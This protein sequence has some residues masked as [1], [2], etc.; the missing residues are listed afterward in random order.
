MDG[1]VKW[2]PSCQESKPHGAASFCDDCGSKLENQLPVKNKW[3]PGCKERKSGLSKFCGD[4]GGKLEDEP[5]VK[6]WCPVCKERKSGLSKFCGDCGGK[7]ED[8]P[9]VKNWCSVC[10]EIVLTKFC[11]KCGRRPVESNEAGKTLIYNYNVASS[12]RSLFD[13]KL[14]VVM[15]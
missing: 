6:N 13:V 14:L 8:E 11:I 15:L 2:C 4:C 12:G 10:E 9:T 3:C 5:T 1:D 7:L